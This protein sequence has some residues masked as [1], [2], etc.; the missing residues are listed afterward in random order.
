MKTS[1]DFFYE[2][3]EVPDQLSVSEWADKYR[4][5]SSSASAEPGFW[6]TSR[7]PY[8]KEIMDALSVESPVQRIVFMK[9]SQIGGSE[10]LNNWI[11]YIIDHAPAAMLAVQPTVEMQK[12][13]S[14]SRI[15]PL[16]EECPQLKT[17][18]KDPRSRDS[19]NTILS[20]EFPGGI[21]VMTGANSAVGLRSLPAKY[22]LLD[23]IDGY[24]FNVDEEGDPISIAQGRSRTY[25]NR[26]KAAL[27]STPTVE[28]K[29]RIAMEFDA[30]DRRYYNV[31][32]PRCS[33]LIILEWNQV[34]WTEG[35]E[36]E[37]YYECQKCNGKI[38]N[39]EKTKMLEN[40]VWIPQNPGAEGGLTR[41]YHINTLYSPVG[42]TSFGDL[43]MEF[44]KAKKSPEKL[45]AFINTALGETWKDKGE[46]PDWKRLYERREFYKTNSI[47]KGVLFLTAG[48]DVQQDRLEVEIVGWGRNKE[49]WSVDYRIYYGDTAALDS[50]PWQELTKLLSET[51]KLVNGVEIPI[52]L[53]A[54]DS[55]FR[56]QTVYAF[57]RQFSIS[58]IIAVKGF[59]NQPTIISNSRPVDVNFKGKKFRRGL[60]LFPL[61][62]SIAKAEL[63]GWLR[64]ESPDEGKPYP[65]GYCH[66]PEYSEEYFK[67]LTA[68]EQ[69]T[70]IVKGY[71]KLEWEKIRDR[72]ES[73][74]L[75]IYARA[76][77]AVCGIDRWSEAHYKQLENQ[78][79]LTGFQSPAPQKT[80]DT[81]DEQTSEKPAEPPNTFQ[82]P[83]K[84][85]KIK[86]RKTNW[87]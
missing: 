32:C 84:K 28:G 9:S 21:L 2:G 17:K 74:D 3:L 45:R 55:G 62:V 81:T 6:R 4:V 59:E 7:T 13:N 72:N 16:I 27:V 1:L 75:R 15:G 80:K 11:G 68:E 12:R 73:L 33:E 34:K 43:A 25:G 46:A 42:W 56:T 71:K 54:I 47:Q 14:R 18:V 48:V 8:L 65:Y 50:E 87:L 38:K 61:G 53:T 23:E 78:L 60:K 63:Y 77:A 51:W 66:F 35:K 22:L 64:Q 76:A 20:K 57:V 82:K 44:K 39:H 24:P 31:P 52:R 70:R 49:S 86:R 5:L 41:G 67:M 83:R 19:G 10:C 85:V 37:A 40:G 26:R 58:K 69:V 30:S 79:G 36:T 29:S